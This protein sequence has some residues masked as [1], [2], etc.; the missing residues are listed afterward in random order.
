VMVWTRCGGVKMGVQERTRTACV[1][2]W[3]GFGP[4]M[5]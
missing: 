1:V 5:G 3:G 2:G 4:V